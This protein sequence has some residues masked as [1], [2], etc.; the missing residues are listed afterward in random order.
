[1]NERLTC[2]EEST[3]KGEKKIV[4]K[5]LA[6]IAAAKENDER[7]YGYDDEHDQEHHDDWTW[8]DH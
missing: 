1:M 3:E 5:F 8:N 6:R 2:K 7:N 4:S